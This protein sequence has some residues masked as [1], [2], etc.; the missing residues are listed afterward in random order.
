MITFNDFAHDDLVR[1][2]KM[3]RGQNII[4]LGTVLGMLCEYEIDYT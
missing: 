3:D 1:G 4:Y 2:W